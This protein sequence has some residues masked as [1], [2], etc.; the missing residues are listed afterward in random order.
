MKKVVVEDV[1]V[2]LVLFCF[3]W[4]EKKHLVCMLCG[5]IDYRIK[6]WYRSWKE[7]S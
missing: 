3:R 5:M 1:C 7:I 2:G 4:E 6:I